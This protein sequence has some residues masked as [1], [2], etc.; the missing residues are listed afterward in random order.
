MVVER[1]RDGWGRGRGWLWKGGGVVVEGGRGGISTHRIGPLISMGTHPNEGTRR[2]IECFLG[3]ASSH[4]VYL[5]GL[6]HTCTTMHADLALI[7]INI[8]S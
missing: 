8:Y 1:G 6:G 5:L 7:N 3:H 2:T 4:A